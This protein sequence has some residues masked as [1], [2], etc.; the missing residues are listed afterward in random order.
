MSLF[1]NIVEIGWISREITIPEGEKRDICFMSNIGTPQPY[2][3]IIGAR[4][5][6]TNQSFGNG[7]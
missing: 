7:Y 1:I 6:G 3:V 5:K 2:T 4:G